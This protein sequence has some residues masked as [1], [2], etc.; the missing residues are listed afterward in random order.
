MD[1]IEKIKKNQHIVSSFLLRKFKTLNKK[2]SKELL[3]R[4]TKD[5]IDYSRKPIKYKDNIFSKEPN[6]IKNVAAKDVIFIENY[7]YDL[8]ENFI[9]SKNDINYKIYVQDLE[10]IYSVI[11]KHAGFCIARIQKDLLNED[12]SVTT[13][14]NQ[15][16]INLLIAFELKGRRFYE[17]IEKLRKKQYFLKM[18]NSN[19]EKLKSI[20]NIIIEM[21]AHMSKDKLNTLEIILL[22]SYLLAFVDYIGNDSTINDYIKQ[23]ILLMN[24][25]WTLGNKHEG[26]NITIIKNITN[27]DFVLGDEPLLDLH[28]KVLIKKIFGCYFD[29][30]NYDNIKIMPITP[31][32]ALLSTKTKAVENNIFEIKEEDVKKIN[33][34]EV[35]NSYKSFVV[36]DDI[37]VAELIDKDFLIKLNYSKFRKQI[38]NKLHNKFFSES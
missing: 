37:I 9:Y 33:S 34:L 2:Y 5:F 25:N 26:Y 36:T 7:F 32:I 20:M 13:E 22:T 15:N 35:F 29:C 17:I 30:T 8:T 4:N 28:D 10:N 12:F 16:L 24:K 14:E 19:P 38:I 1:D 18:L 31:N 21:Q 23:M 11:E 6:L 3:V 27:V